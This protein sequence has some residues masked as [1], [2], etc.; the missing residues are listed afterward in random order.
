[1]PERLCSPGSAKHPIPQKPV[2]PK[3]IVPHTM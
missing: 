3:S 2:D 1:L